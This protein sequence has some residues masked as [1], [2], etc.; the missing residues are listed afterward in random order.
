[1]RRTRPDDLT[2]SECTILRHFIER[3][4]AELED[5]QQRDL[6]G[7]DLAGN[8]NPLRPKKK[9]PYYRPHPAQL[10]REV[11]ISRKWAKEVCD[12]FVSEL[13]IF[14]AE[15]EFT[16]NKKQPTLHY[17]LKYGYPVFKKL[18]R[19]IVTNFNPKERI[20]LLD[21]AFLRQN[22]DEYLV[23][24]ILAEKDVL[25]YSQID[26]LEWKEK[27]ANAFFSEVFKDR[28][29]FYRD[30]Q[31]YEL[32]EV[33]SANSFEEYAQKAAFPSERGERCGPISTLFMR[34]PM[35]PNS[36]KKDENIPAVIKYHNFALDTL[37]NLYKYPSAI[38]DYYRFHEKENI[39]LPILAL[40]LSSPIALDEF[41]NGDW[42]LNMD[43]PSPNYR[44]DGLDLLKFP[45]LLEMIFTTINDIIKT[46]TTPEQGLLS[47][48]WVRPYRP[49]EEENESL[50]KIR[51]KNGYVIQYDARFNTTHDKSDESTSH[52]K[53]Q[54]SI[55][56]RT[57]ILPF[58]AIMLGERDVLK[59]PNALVKDLKDDKNPVS[60]FLMSK[61]SHRFQNIIKYHPLDEDVSDYHLKH[62]L[63]ELN[64]TLLEGPF[65]N[66]LAFQELIKKEDPYYYQPPTARPYDH[67]RWPDFDEMTWQNR[68]LIE[69]AYP[70]A[71]KRYTL[72]EVLSIVRKERE[73]RKNSN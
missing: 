37:P 61:F 4:S 38:E 66:E 25:I 67:L 5:V 65:Q 39:I 16:P 34:F 44:R 13:S 59:N 54:Y 51:L 6:S 12:K 21:C 68:V 8:E 1:M 53:N 31:Q 52:E 15:K 3:E 71:F 43:N 27:E 40:I 58:G 18:V 55:D 33:L 50:L 7:K 36:Y 24:K 48:V 28:S 57:T 9:K 73:K 69:K 42:D 30:I 46:R 14:D 26:I 47:E 23:K 10:S 2:V 70:E 63:H 17:R 72:E 56:I 11:N 29:Q 60:R 20:Q 41:V 22:I 19:I 45:F 32:A 35:F 49:S 62:L 64:R